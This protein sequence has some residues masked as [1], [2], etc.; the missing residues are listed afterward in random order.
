MD[1]QLDHFHADARAILSNKVETAATESLDV[2][3]I[4]LVSMTMALFDGLLPIIELTE[5]RPF[6]SGLKLRRAQTESHRT[7]H[8]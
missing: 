4:D 7:A 5:S 8:M 2:V 3:R 1:F 6:A